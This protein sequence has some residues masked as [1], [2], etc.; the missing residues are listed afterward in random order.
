MRKV[1]R[2][3]IREYIRLGMAED[4]TNSSDA[5]NMLILITGPATPGEGS[6][7]DSLRLC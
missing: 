7:N 5:L 2:R 6:K 1:T 4:V 3:E